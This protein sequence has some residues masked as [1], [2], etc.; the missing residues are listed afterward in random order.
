MPLDGSNG[1]DDEQIGQPLDDR[2]RRPIHPPAALDV[3]RHRLDHGGHGVE[4]TLVRRV[5]AGP[6][7]ARLL[8][9][10]DPRQAPLRRD[11]VARVVV[12]G[13]RCSS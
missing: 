6:H 9:A 12:S 11:V 13:F 4:L 2:P 3:H 8:P 5:V 7:R 10:G 1:V